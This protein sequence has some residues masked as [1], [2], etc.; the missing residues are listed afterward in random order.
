MTKELRRTPLFDLH[1]A[2]GARIVDFAGWEMPVQYAGLIEEHRAVRSGCGIF[3]VSHMGEIE[4]SGR[5]AELACNM[6]T[7]NNAETLVDGKCQ[8][9]IVCNESG[10]ALD[11]TILYRINSE[12]FIFCVNASN[13]EKI[14]KW[15]S[16]KVGQLADVVDRSPEYGLIAIQGPKARAVLSR[17][18]GDD[19]SGIKGFHFAFVDL[20]GAAVML[21]RT[22]YTGE[23]GFEIFCPVA[24]TV[25][26]WNALMEAGAVDGIT[27]V[28]LGAR[29]TLRLEMGY[30]LYGHELTEQTTPAEA[31]LKRFISPDGCDYIGKEVIAG[32]LTGGVTRRL[33]GIEMIDRAIPR[34]GYCVMKDGVK[35]GEVTSGTFSPSLERPIA[36][37]Y[38]ASAMAETG[39]EVEIDVRGRMRSAR[40]AKLPF[41]RRPKA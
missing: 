25:K 20:C 40:V 13:V 11:D 24:S 27:P 12:K 36:M 19:T 14:Y 30:P 32:Q 9:T 22:G 38:I 18:T 26:I 33:V 16:A 7:T 3:D 5:E 23:D 37:A 8:Y 35:V 17:I 31:G 10:M 15:I 4:V 41:Y 34:A 28:G 29:D 6:V 1:K 39:T 2:L 21:S